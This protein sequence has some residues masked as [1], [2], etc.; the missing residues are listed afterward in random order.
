MTDRTLVRPADLDA[1]RFDD[2]GLVPVVAQDTRGGAVLMVAWANRE[3]LA[4]SLETGFMHYWSR[5]R[6]ALWRKGET[7]GNLQ[8][9]V[10]L[11]ADCDADTVLAR[12]SMDGPACHTGEATCFGELPAGDTGPGGSAVLDELWG[13]LQERD[14]ERPEGSW[15]TRLLSDENLRLKKIGEETV[16]LVTALVRGDERASEEA[17]DLVY[18]VMVALKGAGREWDEVLAELARRRR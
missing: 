10:S 15:T 17:A 4:L 8:A 14:R 5:S 16:E 18:H 7:S 12:V 6:S 1:L 9:V 11:H 3:A 2:R 13:V